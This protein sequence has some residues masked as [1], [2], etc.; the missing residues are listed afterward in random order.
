MFCAAFY[1]LYPSLHYALRSL[2]FFEFCQ[3][4]GL[5]SA[6]PTYRRSDIATP[7]R[8]V[9]LSGLTMGTSPLSARPLSTA[10]LSALSAL[11]PRTLRRFLG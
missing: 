6:R 9:C 1:G 2:I 7:F 3:F 8:P 5:V 10:F 11:L 4:A